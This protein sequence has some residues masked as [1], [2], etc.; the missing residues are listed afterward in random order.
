MN[1]DLAE[2]LRF[3]AT[4]DALFADLAAFYARL[5]RTIDSYRPTCWNKGACCKF[6][7]FGHRL[8]VTAIELAYFVREQRGS[9][10][11]ANG[12]AA[13]PYQVE[14]QC[15]ARAARPMGCRV[16]FCDPAAEHW[17]N[18]VYECYL[19]ELKAIGERHGVPYRY[20]EWLSAL[21]SVGSTELSILSREAGNAGETAGSPTAGADKRSDD[22]TA[23][24][25]SVDPKRSNVIELPQVRES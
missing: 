8:Y 1:N 23:T 22:T 10:L 20:M 5:D 4:N 6:G 2:I 3:A 21:A 17:Q 11:G 18:P 12:A 19:G 25:G 16:F 15:T 13:C 7:E 24:A 14:G 9:W